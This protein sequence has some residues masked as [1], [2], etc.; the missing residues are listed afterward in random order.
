MR[1]VCGLVGRIIDDEKD[2]DDGLG[3]HAGDRGRADVLDAPGVVAQARSDPVG[4]DLEQGRPA[5]VGIDQAD[6]AVE[7]L[8]GADGDGLE[9]G[10][11]GRRS[12]VVH[13]GPW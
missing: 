4:L 8:D 9:V 2:V 13:G 5:G 12:I 11:G 7:P 10:Q 6:G 3:R 1:Q